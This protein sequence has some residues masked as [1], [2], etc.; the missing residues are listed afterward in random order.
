M[1]VSIVSEQWVYCVVVCSH[2]LETLRK[3]DLEEGQRD[4]GETN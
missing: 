1:V 2:H 4:G 3:E